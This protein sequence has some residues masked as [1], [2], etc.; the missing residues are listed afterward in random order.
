M[1]RRKQTSPGH[2]R[3]R[4]IACWRDDTGSGGMSLMMLVTSIALLMILGLI[5]DGGAKAR[6]L[7]Q[8]DAIAAETARVAAGTYRPGDTAIDPA[9]ANRAASDY[10]AAA[11]ATGG[12]TIS[13]L[14]VTA[15]AA[16]HQTT[17]FLPLVGIDEFTVT[18]SGNAVVVYQ[19]GGTP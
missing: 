17:V 9:A 3:E 13:G 6:A 11:D 12:I 19:P 1:T 4:V 7:D 2:R 18:G 15:T 16:L 10:L 8:A 14:A 5:V